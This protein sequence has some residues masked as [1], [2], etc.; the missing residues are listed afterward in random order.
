MT[1]DEELAKLD[2]IEADGRAQFGDDKLNLLDIASI[3]HC[4]EQFGV[5]LVVAYY[6]ARDLKLLS[7]QEPA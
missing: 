2:K 6:R 4:A 1:I 5:P 7:Y 3:H